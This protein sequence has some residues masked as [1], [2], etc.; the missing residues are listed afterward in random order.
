MY[1]I[2]RPLLLRMRVAA[3]QIGNLGEG[4]ENQLGI[5]C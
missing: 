4:V 1:A 5:N 2:Q 3:S